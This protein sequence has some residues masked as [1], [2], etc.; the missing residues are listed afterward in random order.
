M[1]DPPREH[2]LDLAL[3]D[4]SPSKDERSRRVSRKMTFGFVLFFVPFFLVVNPGCL[5]YLQATVSLAPRSCS[6]RVSLEE[7][8]DSD[9]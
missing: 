9:S 3:L 4:F 8:R 7:G 5:A 6:R 2:A 1:K